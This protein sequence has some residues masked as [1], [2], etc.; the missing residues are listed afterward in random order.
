MQSCSHYIN[1]DN[2]PLVLQWLGMVQRLNTF[3]SEQPSENTAQE[4]LAL[5]LMVLIQNEYHRK[6]N[7]EKQDKI[8][9][10]KS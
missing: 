1:T 9:N 7:D 2:L 5:H 8:R 4:F 10:S 3:P 6:E